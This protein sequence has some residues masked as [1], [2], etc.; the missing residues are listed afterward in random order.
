MSFALGIKAVRKLCET[1]D[2]LQ[3][4]RAKLTPFLFSHQELPAFEWVASHL[5]KHH[6]LPSLQTLQ[7]QF[8]DVSQ[9]DTP[10]PVSYYVE[11]L[12][13]RFFHKRLD[14][15]IQK[16]HEVLKTNQTDHEEA[17]V[18]LADALKEIR[19]QK[20]RTRLLDV[21][22]ESPA[23]VMSAY[24]NVAMVE[25]VSSFGWPYMDEQSGGVMPGEIVSFVGR[26]AT[27]KTWLSLWT[28]MHNWRASG[29]QK[30]VNTLFVSMEM[31]LL[32]IAQRIASMYTECTITQLKNAGFATDMYKKF[33][34]SL[35]LMTKEQAKFYVID[36]NLAASVE[37][38]FLLADI[39]D[40]Q[41][42]L[43]DGAYLVRHSNP[44]L[45]RFVRA[46]EN[47]ELM[48]RYTTE[49]GKS[50]FTSWQFNRNAS[51]KK[52]SASQGGDDVGLEDIGYTDAIGQ[53]SSMVL[54]LFQ[55][56]G[57]ETMKSRKIRV[58]KGRNGEVGQF[59]INWDFIHMHFDQL[60][61]AADGEEE[62]KNKELQWV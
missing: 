28:A 6:V 24:H 34:S 17:M 3:W 27:G 33:S 62:E 25:R 32:P 41:T 16:A 22:K 8:P 61:P 48:K 14:D 21:G 9:I 18:V 29:P 54:G 12:E 5:K 40:C 45:D 47:I 58:L 30:G 43:I 36:G 49:Q 31:M 46:A 38:I 39:L 20:Y 1:Q 10:E 42:V 37:D 23:L 35:Q 13:N 11:L 51:H 52:K 57:I 50:V 44:R 15:A 2:K 4:Q 55:E 56:E 26:P 59:I 7:Q 53:I 60:E 19:T